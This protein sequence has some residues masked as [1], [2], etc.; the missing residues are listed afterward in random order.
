[1]ES[2]LIHEIGHALSYGTGLNNGSL[3]LKNL[4]DFINEIIEKDK[5][6]T[7]KQDGIDFLIELGYP[8]T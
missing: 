5:P 1:M 7:F 6:A 3:S 2:V 4:K 8:R